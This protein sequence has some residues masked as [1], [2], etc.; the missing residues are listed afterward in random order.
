MQPHDNSPECR[1]ATQVGNRHDNAGRS[2]SREACQR[3][4]QKELCEEPTLNFLHSSR[5]G[6]FSYQHARRKHRPLPNL[7]TAQTVFSPS[8]RFITDIGRPTIARGLLALLA[9]L[10]LSVISVNAERE[11]PETNAQRFARGLP[12]LPAK[13]LRTL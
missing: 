12:P 8:M 3:D 11:A 10:F 7:P 13:R 5:A 6:S 4:P 2:M 9:I 1:V